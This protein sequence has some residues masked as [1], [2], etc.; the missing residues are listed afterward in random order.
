[1]SSP[2]SADEIKSKPRKRAR[3][4]RAINAANQ[5]DERHLP[6]KA[7][8]PLP[9]CSRSAVAFPTVDLAQAPAGSARHACSVSQLPT[10]HE[11][12]R[13]NSKRAGELGRGHC[14]RAI[15]SR[16]VRYQDPPG[17]QGEPGTRGT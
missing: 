11:A 4:D 2:R 9:G 8:E 17:E 6:A 7:A 10:A 12:R 15:D 14:P 13:G 1:M 3:G 5:H 16:D